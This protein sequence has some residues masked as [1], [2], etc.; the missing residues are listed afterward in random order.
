MGALKQERKVLRRGKASGTF[1]REGVAAQEQ[2]HHNLATEL[3]KLMTRDPVALTWSLLRLRSFLLTHFGREEGH[4][5]LFQLVMNRAWQHQNTVRELQHEHG[6]ILVLL[7]EVLAQTKQR[8][9]PITDGQRGSVLQLIRVLKAHEATE[10]ELLQDVL[11]TDVGV[12][13]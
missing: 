10:N 2:D 9:D 5:G 3:D 12:G 4:N 11:Q 7:D 8:F 1:P 6:A 13:D